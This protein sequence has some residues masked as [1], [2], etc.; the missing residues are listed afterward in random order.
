M[1]SQK[2]LGQLT[3]RGQD[4]NQRSITCSVKAIA[5]QPKV[6][7]GLRQGISRRHIGVRGVKGGVK[8]GKLRQIR[9]QCR[10]GLNSH[11]IGR[12]VQWGKGHAGCD[13]GDHLGRHPAGRRQV[14]PA[15][16]HP[17]RRT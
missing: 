7:R 5:T 9:G 1:A 14:S 3:A 6:S 12:I 8:A 15:M 2:P 13:P 10:N 11:Q 16:H 17:M 4:A